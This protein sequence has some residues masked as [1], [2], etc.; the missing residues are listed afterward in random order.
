MS[1]AALGFISF[2]SMGVNALGIGA[3]YFQRKES[4]DLQRQ[5]LNESM[6]SNYYSYMQQLESMQNEYGQDALAI[7]QQ[8]ENIASNM[9]YLDRWA[10]EYD[11]SMQNGIDESFGQYQQLAS[12]Y[13]SGLVSNAETGR[14]GGSA[15]RLA[16]DAGM[17]LASIN[18]G[19]TNGFNLTGSRLGSYLQSAA[20]DMMADRQT[21]ISAVGTGYQAI[22]SYQ[23]AMDHLQ[24]SI[25]SM[26]NTTGQMATELKKKNIEV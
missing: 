17:A 14:R 22:G 21:A 10:S 18:G 15:G 24:T 6:R 11:L 4:N 20:L 25:G 5:S 19:S 3:N 1:L 16:G 12:N 9:N 7:N 23:K 26:E 13:A 2:L 8:R